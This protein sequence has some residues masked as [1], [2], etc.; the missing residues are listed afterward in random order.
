MPPQANSTQGLEKKPTTISGS[1]KDNYE[2]DVVSLPYEGEQVG[3]WRSQLI[4]PHRSYVNGFTTDAL[5]MAVA[6]PMVRREIQRLCPEG[7][8]DVVYYEDG[9]LG[10]ESSYELALGEEVDSGL[11]TSLTTAMDAEDFASLLEGQSWDL[12][13]YAHQMTQGDI[14]PYDSQLS[15]LVCSHWMTEYLPQAV[16]SP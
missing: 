4:R 9:H 11:L 14:A 6:V 8:Q 7:C 3:E 15:S 13:V 1:R 16:S 2:F 12:V 5:D 10:P